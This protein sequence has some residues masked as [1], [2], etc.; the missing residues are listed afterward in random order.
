VVLVDE[1]VNNSPFPS[2]FLSNYKKGSIETN[3][4]AITN[5]LF[6]PILYELVYFK[7]WAPFSE[8]WAVYLKV[9]CWKLKIAAIFATQF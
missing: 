1:N 6:R 2:G 3:P 9:I 7:Y 5:D 4:R 8:E